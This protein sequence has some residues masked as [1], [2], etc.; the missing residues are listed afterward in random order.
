MPCY[1]NATEYIKVDM[2]ATLAPG[3]LLIFCT[4]IFL[5]HSA[6][7][8]LEMSLKGTWFQEIMTEELTS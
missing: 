2:T 4:A 8:H 5:T 6:A 7:P 1:D 3:L